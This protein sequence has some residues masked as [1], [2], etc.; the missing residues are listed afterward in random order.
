MRARPTSSTTRGRAAV[1][2]R[3]SPRAARSRMRGQPR[4]QPTLRRRNQ[5]PH[6]PDRQRILVAQRVADVQ[7]QL[8]A[9]QQRSMMQWSGPSRRRTQPGAATFARAR[10]ELPS[11]PPGSAS[12]VRP[13]RTRIRRSTRSARRSPAVARRHPRRAISA[14]EDVVR[15]RDAPRGTTGRPR[16]RAEAMGALNEA[17]S[18]IVSLIDRLRAAGAAD[19][20]GRGGVPGRPEHPYGSAAEAF[21]KVM[22]APR[23]H[24][25]LV[26]RSPA[27]RRERRPRG[28]RS[29]RRTHGWLDRLQL[30]GAELPHPRVRGT[31]ETIEGNWQTYGMARSSARCGLRRP[32]DTARD[33]RVV[34]VL[35]CEAA[36]RGAR[37][38]RRGVR[39]P[40]TTCNHRRAR[41]RPT[42]TSVP[43]APTASRRGLAGV[44]TR[45]SRPQPHT[46]HAAHARRLPGAPRSPAGALGPAATALRIVVGVVVAP[47]MARVRTSHADTDV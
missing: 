32:L 4:S 26:L 31:R 6:P 19:V 15:G 10:R 7:A 13:P 3:R 28:T 16:S 20:N 8:A 18:E 23:C 14:A 9:A 34:V 43:A 12:S 41:C 38:R 36:V 33:R 11:G 1:P 2:E 22:G 29:R 40:I 46:Q 21:L 35:W 42:R 44:A 37:A 47:L 5:A 25:N 24:A 30:V 17:R 27:G 39:G 45:P